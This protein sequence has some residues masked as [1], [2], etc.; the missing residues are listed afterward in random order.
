[1]ELEGTQRAPD[2][3]GPLAPLT[4]LSLQGPVGIAIFSV[5]V[6]SSKAANTVKPQ[7]YG[8]PSNVGAQ[9]PGS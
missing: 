6:T 2:R 5:G 4:K 1:M 7:G 3:S 9:W 8:L